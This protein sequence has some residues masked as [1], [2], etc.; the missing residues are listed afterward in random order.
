MSTYIT[1]RLLRALD[2]LGRCCKRHG[3]H[4]KNKQKALRVILRIYSTIWHMFRIPDFSKSRDLNVVKLLFNL[5]IAL[6]SLSLSLH[7]SRNI[8]NPA[9]YGW[10]WV[11][12]LQTMEKGNFTDILRQTLRFEW[13]S[14]YLFIIQLYQLFPCDFRCRIWFWQFDAPC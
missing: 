7:L 9:V 5:I 10:A 3:I 1:E 2:N 13:L 8:W 12:G 6:H 4:W 14:Y 11:K